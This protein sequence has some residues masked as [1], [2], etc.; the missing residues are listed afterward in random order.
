MSKVIYEVR[1]RRENT[2]YFMAYLFDNELKAYMS[3]NGFTESSEYAEVKLE[4]RE[5][6]GDKTVRCEE[7]GHY[8]NIIKR[9]N[10]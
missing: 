7:I 2:C 1:V 8:Q 3:Y 4:L 10:K 9:R 6:L 5:I